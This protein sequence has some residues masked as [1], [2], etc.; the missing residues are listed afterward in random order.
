M[1]SMVI[2]DLELMYMLSKYYQK[3]S[4]INTYTIDKRRSCYYKGMLYVRD[5]AEY[6][7]YKRLGVNKYA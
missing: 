3:L 6:F 2:R 7:T 1:N 5:T 4:K